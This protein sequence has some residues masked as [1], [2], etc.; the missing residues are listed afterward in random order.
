M[1]NS[2][3]TWGLADEDI[4]E[5]CLLFWDFTEFLF[6]FLLWVKALLLREK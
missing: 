3:D 5:R 1:E 6:H 4:I 2:N